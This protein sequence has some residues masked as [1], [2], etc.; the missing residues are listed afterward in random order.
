MIDFLNIITT[1]AI[2]LFAG[3][4]L[5]EA[6]ILVPYWRKMHPDE[7][8]RLHGS[9]GF[10]LFRFFAPL[11]TIA[12][13][14]SVIS[15]AIEIGGENANFLL[16]ASTIFCLIALAIFFLYFKKANKKFADHSLNA[17]ELVMELRHWAIWHWFRTGLVVAAFACSITAYTS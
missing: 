17:E 4:L 15:G 9:I 14:L 2:G 7:F 6:C 1:L 10:N 8:F 5:T 11:T 13:V 12:V 3:A 16:L